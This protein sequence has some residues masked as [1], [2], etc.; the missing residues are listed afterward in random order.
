LASAREQK[1]FITNPAWNDLVAAADEMIRK[2][3]ASLRGFSREGNITKINVQ[4]GVIEGIERWRLRLANLKK[5]L[6]LK[7]G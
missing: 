1:D 7:E 4:A 5:E 3:N 6:D 2:E